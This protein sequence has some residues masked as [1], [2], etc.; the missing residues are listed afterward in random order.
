MT[1]RL[2]LL[3]STSQWFPAGGPNPFINKTDM[4]FAVRAT[5]G[6]APQLDFTLINS[7]FPVVLLFY[8]SELHRAGML[9]NWLGA[10]SPACALQPGP[11]MTRQI[12]VDF[13]P[14]HPR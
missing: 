3:L 8:P 13:A 9:I 12:D 6:T 7:R 2:C 11:G 5:N 10:A 14:T 1:L 4:S